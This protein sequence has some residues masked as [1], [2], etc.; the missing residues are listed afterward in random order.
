[1]RYFLDLA[2]QGTAYN[3]WQS[4]LNAPSV[5]ESVEKALSTL[6]RTPTEIV[7]SGRTDTGVHAEQQFAHFDMFEKEGENIDLPTLKHRLNGLL[8]FDIA[9]KHIQS[10]HD[11]AHARFDAVERSYEYRINTQKNPFLRGLAYLYRPALDLTLMNESAGKL[12]EY[13][14]FQAFSKTGS[15][16]KHFFCTLHRAEWVQ[17]EVGY[18]FHITA[19]R[20]LYGMVRALVGT[21]LEVGAGKLSSMDFEKILQSK[22]R[23]NAKR[24]APPEG[25]FLTKVKY[26]YLS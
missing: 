6:L 13:T 24:A 11:T 18:T 1:M 9:I 17:T 15:N 14:D 2:Y 23:Q 5:Q 19:N 7:G 25:L 8:P 21:L 22:N 16:N 3:G 26:P 10:V 20:F 4:Q 12:L